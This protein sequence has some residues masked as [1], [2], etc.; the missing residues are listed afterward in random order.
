MS[1]FIFVIFVM[2][3]ASMLVTSGI[4]VY[5]RDQVKGLNQRIS[6]L[7]AK[8][9]VLQ[10]YD[11]VGDRPIRIYSVD[12][13]K[14]FIATDMNDSLLGSADQKLVGQILSQ[15]PEYRLGTGK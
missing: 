10:G 2:L 4:V 9:V 6:T 11:F 5:Y 1:K 7:N 15:H 3:I 12:Y 14:S 13:G 8:Y